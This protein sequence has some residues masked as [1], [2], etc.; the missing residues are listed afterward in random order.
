MNFYTFICAASCKIL[1][2]H[3]SNSGNVL[4]NSFK[5]A[6]MKVLKKPLSNTDEVLGI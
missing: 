3:K 4:T 2:S 5:Q 1:F 6:L